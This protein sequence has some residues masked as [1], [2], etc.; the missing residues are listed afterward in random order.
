MI[1]LLSSHTEQKPFSWSLDAIR[2]N[3]INCEAANDSAVGKSNECNQVL[4]SV[5]VA[6]EV[7]LVKWIIFVDKFALKGSAAHILV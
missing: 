2:I 3:R 7:N 5:E 6:V 1:N 4:D